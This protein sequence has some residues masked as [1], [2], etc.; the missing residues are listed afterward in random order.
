METKPELRKVVLSGASGMLGTALRRA[1][2]V[3]GATCLQLVRRVAASE[4]ELQWNP[5]SEHAVDVPAAL[6]GATAAIHLSGANVAGRR[7]TGAYRRELRA[8]RIDTTRRL[9]EVLAQ[10]QRPPK[11]FL[12]A[13]A[14]GIYGNRGDEVLTESSSTGSGF[15]AEL[16]EA[17]EDAAAPALR[18]GIRVVHLRFGIV[19]GSGGALGRMLPA[20]R[21]GMGAR[22]GSGNQWMS[23]VGLD[24]AVAAVLFAMENSDASGALNV[25][26]PNPVTNAEFTREL[27]RQLRRPAFLT[28]PAFAVRIVFGQ[29]ADEALL[30]ST[31][32][33]PEGLQEAGFRFSAPELG[34]ALSEALRR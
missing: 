4:E 18:R 28:V 29:M 3:R 6:E 19:L 25:T 2:I 10:L 15:L 20:F 24:D 33:I 9:A 13:S 32:A 22:I 31:R 27:G 8:S 1:L 26:A 21:L 14:I 30:S 5:E 12:V 11:V 34:Q 23:W 7:W 17:W 16:C